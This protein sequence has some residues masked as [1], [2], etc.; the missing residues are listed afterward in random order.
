MDKSA[1]PKKW[2]IKASPQ[3]SKENPIGSKEGIPRALANLLPLRGV[4]TDD[5]LMRFLHPTLD[6]LP[7]PDELPGIKEGSNLLAKAIINNF[8]IVIYGDYD[9]D[10]ITATAL[11]SL[12]LRDLGV[13][14][15]SYLPDREGEGYGLHTKAIKKIHDDLSKN[16]PNKPL[17]L[18]TVDCG[19]SN[20]DE[21]AFAKELGFQVIVTDH[22][23]P[24]KALP[25]ANILINPRLQITNSPFQILAGVGVAFYL[26]AGLRM[27]LMERGVFSKKTPPNLKNYLDLVALGTIADMVPLIGV[28]R[29]MVKAGLE[30][31]NKSPRP[32]IE[33]LLKY[34]REPQGQIRSETI[35]FQLAPRINAAGRMGCPNR[36]LDLL[37][38]NSVTSARHLS[39]IIDKTNDKRRQLTD[40]CYAQAKEKQHE[41][42]KPDQSSLVLVFPEWRQGILGL[43]AGRIAQDINR[44]VAVF[45]K[46]DN[47]TLKGSI[48]SIDGVDIISVLN[49]CSA[50]LIQFG[51]HSAAAGLTIDQSQ[52]DRFTEKFE[53]IISLSMKEIYLEPVVHIDHEINIEETMT[54]I[55]LDKYVLFEPF[56]VGNPEPIFSCPN[57]VIVTRAEQ[58]GKNTLYYQIQ[59]NEKCFDGIGF[60]MGGLSELLINKKI[61]LAFKISLNSFRGKQRWELRA[62]DI[63]LPA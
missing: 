55:F 44:P 9:A 30:I 39:E 1:P 17:I 32:G 56:G 6:Q 21:V 60:G 36:A 54:K 24:P 11:L 10:G 47:C 3:L 13:T 26:A 49:Q 61:K 7:N 12:F 63:K 29:I 57:T 18:I 37:M 22:H 5:E 59:E 19:I 31:I 2:L 46:T 4:N 16:S 25:E 50:E 14:S 62:E 27:R 41:N 8:P 28:N 48:R 40:L 38:S 35:A 15:S 53:E 43:I 23:H 42:I 20:K 58:R 51:G 45:A 34:T 52:L 33:A